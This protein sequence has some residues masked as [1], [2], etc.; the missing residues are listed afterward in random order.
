VRKHVASVLAC[1]GLAA[2]QNPAGPEGAQRSTFTGPMVIVSSGPGASVAF[3]ADS[4]RDDGQLHAELNWNVAAPGKGTLGSQPPQLLLEFLRSCPGGSCPGSS[5]SG[6]APSGPLS[7]SGD[8][9]PASA[10]LVRTRAQRLCGGCRIEYSLKVDHPGG[11]IRAQPV[12][13]CPAYRAYFPSVTGP[14][15]VI[16]LQASPPQAR[17]S[18]GERVQIAPLAACSF[19]PAYQVEG[20][21]VTSPSVATVAEIGSSGSFELRAERE[22]QTR[23]LFDV[24]HIDGSRVLGELGY[25]PGAASTCSPTPL[26]LNVVR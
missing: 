6:P 19:T 23:L 13:T 17:V 21:T 20:W 22:G 24:V 18:V 10:Y 26:V 16:D 12:S 2:C 15:P 4:F 25:C 1:A 11:S 8:V 3:E 5:S 14:Q 9:H 7:V